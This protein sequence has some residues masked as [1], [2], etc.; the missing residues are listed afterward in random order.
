MGQ[1]SAAPIAV[2]PPPDLE[3]GTADDVLAHMVEQ[4]HPRLL[5]AASFQ[6]ETSVIMDMIT[7]IAPDA[8]FF[9]LDTGVLFPETYR[10]WSEMEEHFGVEV[11]VFQGMSL[12]RQA[13]LHGDELWK[14]NPDACC[15]IRKVA[16][17]KDALSNVDGWITG[18]RR[19]HSR[20][21][22][23]A[24]KVHWDERNEL[25]KANPLADWTEAE[26]W[27][28]IRSREL[29]YNELHDRGY[30]SIGCTHCTAPANGRDG[31][32]AGLDKTECG[33]HD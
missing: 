4:F 22:A 1:L 5:V 14:R 18:V 24:V 29:P 19:E 28:Y 15:G 32:W 16:P 20:T 11:E 21:R 17:L 6:K 7:R 31:R 27:D 23:G 9:T 30:T 2:A 12:A 8:R 10:T 3:Q 13:E 33:L 25:W 26:V